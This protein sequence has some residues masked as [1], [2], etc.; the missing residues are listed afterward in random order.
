MIKTTLKAWRRPIGADKVKRPGLAGQWVSLGF[1]A[2]GLLTLGG[3]IG[4]SSTPAQFY[5]LEPLTETPVVAA[6]AAPTML[7]LAPVRIPH[8]LD[9]AQIVTATGDNTYQLSELNRWAEGLDHN[10]NR[11]LQQD[12]S[13]LVPAD[14]VSSAPVGTSPLKLAVTIQAFHVDAQGQARLE[15]QW[16]LSRDQ[17]TLSVRRQGYREPAST[18]D[19]RL[20]VAALN[21]CLHNMNRDLANDVRIHSQH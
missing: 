8:Y 10:V 1:A 11:V 18:S 9:R 5:L 13:K 3:C 4:G 16:Q 15:A 17:Q 20:M 14:V 21:A 7:V 2:V 19:Y 6:D 12:L